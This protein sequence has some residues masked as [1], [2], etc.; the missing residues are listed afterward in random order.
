[1]EILI[2]FLARAFRAHLHI[3]SSF[4]GIDACL[5]GGLAGLFACALIV[6][7]GTRAKSKG[8]GD[9]RGY[10]HTTERSN[11]LANQSRDRRAGTDRHGILKQRRDDGRHLET[12]AK[13]KARVGSSHC[14]CAGNQGRNPFL[15]V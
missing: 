5:F 15:G 10:F 9:D 14:R 8:E 2:Q 13:F 3:V 7:R 11:S 4:P 1:M 12:S 6:R